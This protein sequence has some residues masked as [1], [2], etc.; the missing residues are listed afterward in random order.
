ML[1]LV[2]MNA[3]FFLA[4]LASWYVCTVFILAGVGLGIFLGIT[5]DPF[6]LFMLFLPFAGLLVL[7]LTQLFWTRLY[8]PYQEEFLK[9]MMTDQKG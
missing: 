8:L 5:V 9:K 7:K 3:V 6:Y 2:Y 1:T 4:L